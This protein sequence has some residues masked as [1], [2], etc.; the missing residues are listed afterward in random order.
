M[1]F[2][3]KSIFW[4]KHFSVS[5]GSIL[6]MQKKKT[7]KKWWSLVDGELRNINYCFEHIHIQQKYWTLR[8]LDSFRFLALF[9]DE[10]QMSKH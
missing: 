5:F 4:I 8:Q 9:D 10:E 1:Q 2:F 7:G 3:S 6:T